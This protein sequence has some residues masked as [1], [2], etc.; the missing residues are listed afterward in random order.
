MR[1]LSA[2]FNG[3]PPLLRDLAIAQRMREKYLERTMESCQLKSVIRCTG[4]P[5]KESRPGKTY[6]A[7]GQEALVS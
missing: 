4:L 6:Q 2:L 1:P 7:D 5:S 3:L